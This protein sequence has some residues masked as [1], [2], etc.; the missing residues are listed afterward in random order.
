[1]LAQ[2]NMTPSDIQ[3]VE[4]APPD[5]PAALY[6]NAVDA[7]CT[8][9]P[10]GAAAQQAGYARPLRMTRDEWRNYICCVLTVREEL[11]QENPAM[12]QDL[13]NQ[14]LG[15][16]VW[17]DQQQE[18]RNKAVAI[19]AGR[20]FFNQDP[21]IIQFVMENPGGSGDLR[22]LANDPRRI[23][24]ADAAVDGCGHDQA[25]HCLRDLRG[26][27]LCEERTRRRHFLVS[28]HE[29]RDPPCAAIGL[30]AVVR[31]RRK[32]PKSRRSRPASSIRHERRRI[33]PFAVPT[34]RHS[35]SAV[36]A[37]RSWC[38]G[39][40]T[41]HVPMSVRPLLRFSRRRIANW[42]RWASQVQIIYLTVDPERDSADRLKQYLAAFDPTFVGGTGTAAA[43]GRGAHRA[44]ASRP[45]NS[46]PEAITPLRT[47]H[48]SIS[49]PV[50]ASCER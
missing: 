25:S 6:A 37:A 42:E 30:H 11:I 22:R 14:V 46:A 40:V 26:R 13:V 24:R 20:E 12:V 39:L 4:M 18:N 28:R 35:L 16:G 32:P 36:I 49:S 33:F 27:D 3:I 23:R 29:L 15:A 43:N 9:E 41:P 34:A 1:M 7:Y 44:M 48:L 50:T 38:W 5:M 10:F 2:E 45:R 8:G 31:W 21:K 17:L 47:R 19:A